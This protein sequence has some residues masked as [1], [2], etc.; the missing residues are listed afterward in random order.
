MLTGFKYIIKSHYSIN[1]AKTI[2]E[3]KAIFQTQKDILSYSHD[4][5][6]KEVQI[7]DSEGFVVLETAT[8]G[9]N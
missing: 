7:L 4:L 5:T 1:G 9:L 2:E 3:A 6:K 8:R